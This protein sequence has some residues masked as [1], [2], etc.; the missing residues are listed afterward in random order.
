MPG[1]RLGVPS[2]CREIWST[3]GCAARE[4]AAGNTLLLRVEDWQAGADAMAGQDRLSA[5]LISDNSAGSPV[6]QAP[7][8]GGPGFFSGSALLPGS[9]GFAPLYPTPLLG[10]LLVPFSAT[11]G[12]GFNCHVVGDV[13]C[14]AT[15]GIP[16]LFTD[17]W[18]TTPP[19]L[20]PPGL[21]GSV[22]Y[23][24]AF[25]VNLTTL[26]IPEGTNVV[27]LVFL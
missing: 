4:L 23:A 14:S 26:T 15:T 18:A 13:P 11:V 3:D 25:S 20:V 5:I 7:P 12:Q 2:L 17:M 24:A 19:I 9:A 21:T 10:Q 8:G 6:G 1:R 22:L 16:S 27:E